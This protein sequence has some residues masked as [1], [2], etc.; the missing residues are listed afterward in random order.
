M[1]YDNNEKLLGLY[2]Q[3]FGHFP[4]AYA[5]ARAPGRVE[6]AGNHTDYQGGKVISAAIGR[7]IHALAAPNNKNV[8]CAYMD[9]YDN[10]TIDLNDPSWKTPRKEEER[11]SAALLRGMAALFHNAGGHVQGCNIVTFSSIPVGSGLSSSAAFE[12]TLA[13]VLK[14][15][16]DI[17]NRVWD[18]KT[19]LA[20]AGVEAEQRYFGKPCGAQDQLASA[21]GGILAMDFAS[22]PPV[23]KPLAFDPSTSGYTICIVNS[24]L[25][26]T[27]YT[28]EF[29]QIS[30][31][32]ASVAEGLHI[33][34][35]CETNKATFL[36]ALPTLRA[37]LGDLACM[38]AL[39]FFTEN[40]RVT[41]Q[42]EALE[43]NNMKAFLHNM[44][45]SGESSA[46]YLQN[47]SP[48]S[49][50]KTE[51]PCMLILELCSQILG[52]KGAWRIH[53]GGFGGGIIAFVPLEE[54]ERFTNQMNTYLG[55][56]ACIR[57]L[58]GGPGASF[59][60]VSH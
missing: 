33:K 23:V 45:L 57:V 35:L 37:S 12:M 22:N 8:I 29:A 50:S 51:Q 55:Y 48:A 2:A 34:K 11:T 20:L 59:E 27:L 41:L 18:D 16:F 25:D 44:H 14:G 40:E 43:N 15:L 9:G 39:H 21:Y 3:Q 26:H 4:P 31:D 38:R 13:H 7:S 5:I 52:N 54:I 19:L 28:H 1:A 24:N 42:L 60:R 10:A 49:G 17:D 46:Q 58:L 32:M 30:T 36:E 56:N 6:L 53:G 47:V